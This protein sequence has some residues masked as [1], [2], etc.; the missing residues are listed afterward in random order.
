MT[1]GCVYCSISGRNLFLDAYNALEV[2]STAC[3]N[4]GLL[5]PSGTT[6]PVFNTGLFFWGLSHQR[7]KHLDVGK[8]GV[9]V[10]GMGV[11]IGLVPTGQVLFQCGTEAPLPIKRFDP[12]SVM[13]Y[14][15]F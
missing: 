11:L 9:P 12:D 8:P 15:A 7:F 1:L 2:S 5:C 6:V 13:C 4:A 3:C 14:S 10:T